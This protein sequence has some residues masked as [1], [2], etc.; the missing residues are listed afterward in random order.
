MSLPPPLPG[1]S[2]G[3]CTVCCV[4]LKIDDPALRKSAGV[5]CVH[6]LPGKGCALHPRHPKTCQ[7]WICGWR[8]L[9]L[10][11]AMRPDRSGILL[12]PELGTGEGYEK[13]GLK[14]VLQGDDRAALAHDELLNLMAKCV[15][16]GVPIYL[17]CGT[18]LA[19]QA[20]INDIAK[21]AVAARGKDEFRRILG[22]LFDAMTKAAAEE[23]HK[24]GT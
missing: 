16:G 7:S 3:E 15:L 24:A 6:M 9:Q 13:G 18:G 12:V 20:L 1:R 23:P 14:I 10:S 8:F 5:A 19:K 17:T 4:A 2:C 11:D 22:D 21:P